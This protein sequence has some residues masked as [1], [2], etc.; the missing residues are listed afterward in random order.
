MPVGPSYCERW[1]SSPLISSG[2][3]AVP[4][5]RT[6]RVWGTSPSSAPRVTTISQPVSSATDTTARQNDLH[7]TLG[8]TPRSTTRSRSS[9]VTAK[10]SFAGHV[11]DRATP[12]TSSI[13]GRCDW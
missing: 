3:E 9:N 13:C 11:I 12:S 2:S 5:T 1:S 8:S 7:R 6:P 10:Q 4:V